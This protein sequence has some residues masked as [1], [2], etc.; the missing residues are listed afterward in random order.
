MI[1]RNFDFFWFS[2]T[3]LATAFMVQHGQAENL[4]QKYLNN[5]F[6]NKA[7]RGDTQF[8]ELFLQYLVTII[9]QILRSLLS[10]LAHQTTLLSLVT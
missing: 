4:F 1:H 6:I 8:M 10:T 3:V 7:D 9:L 2:V 5:S